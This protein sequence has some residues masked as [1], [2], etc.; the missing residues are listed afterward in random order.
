M[1]FKSKKRQIESESDGEQQVVKKSKGETTAKKD[2]T[3][4]KDAEGNP[5]WE[6]GQPAPLNIRYPARR[7]LMHLQIGKNRRIGSSQFKGATLINIR[8]YYTA[9]DGELKP[10]KKVS[11]PIHVV[12]HLCSD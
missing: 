11:Y 9:P 2:L 7:L 12:E 10:G 8:E 1:P 4:G 3:Q 6:V 5:F